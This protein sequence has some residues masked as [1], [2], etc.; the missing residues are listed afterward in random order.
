VTVA[1]GIGVILVWL[2]SI[3]S[4]GVG[5]LASFLVVIGLFVWLRQLQHSVPTP[6]LPLQRLR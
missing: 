4:A 6:E 1:L 3:V 2:F 5:W